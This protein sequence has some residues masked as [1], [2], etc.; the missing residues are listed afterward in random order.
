MATSTNKKIKQLSEEELDK[1]SGGTGGK[2][3]DDNPVI[4]QKGGSDPGSVRPPLDREP[5]V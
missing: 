1:V 3:M 4:L 5:P 2:K